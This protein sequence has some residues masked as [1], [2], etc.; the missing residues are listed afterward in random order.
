[1]KQLVVITMVFVSLLFG[2]GSNKGK[3]LPP[4]APV[5]PKGTI[6]IQIVRQGSQTPEQV[7][8]ITILRGKEEI[9]KEINVDSYA[10][11]GLKLWRL[12]SRGNRLCRAQTEF[13]KES[14][15]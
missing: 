1:M 10:A 7:K 13:S 15:G 4:V 3:K 2:C 11:D 9:H 12:H 14:A 5:T 6:S 8:S